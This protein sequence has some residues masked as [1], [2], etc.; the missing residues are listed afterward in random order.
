MTPRRVR[1]LVA[2]AAAAL[3][4]VALACAAPGL[5][6]GGPPDTKPPV[7]LSVTPDTNTLHAKVKNVVF[8][9]DELVSERP[10]GA[11]ALEQ[12]V[13]ISPAESPPVVDWQRNRLA[14]RPKKGWRANTAYTVTLL[15]GLADLSGNAILKPLQTEFSTG[16]SIPS[17]T[18]RGVVF[19]WVAQRTVAGARIEA[20]M[21]KDT[22]LRWITAADSLGRF[23]LAHV[24]P[25]ADLRLR[26]FHD[27]NG[28]RVLDRRE[29]WDS[30]SVPL[31]D[32]ARR[33]FY[34]FAHDSIAPRLT[35]PTLVDSTALRLKFDR[36]LNPAV[37][38]NLSNVTVR[39]ADST[40]RTLTA[41]YRAGEFDSLKVTL[42]KE[43]DDSVA[44]ADTSKAGRT[45]R[46][47]ADSL[48]AKAVND[49]ISAAQIAAAKAAKDTVKRE[50][51]PKPSRPAPPIEFVLVFDKPLQVNENV[52]L[53]IQGATS[54]DG[55]TR[56]TDIRRVRGPKP[57]PKVDSTATKPGA[58]GRAPAKPAAPDP[59]AKKPAAPDT[60]V[61]KPAPPDT[62]A[63]KPAPSDSLPAKPPAMPA[64]SPPKKP[65]RRSR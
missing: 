7:L 15:P 24:P 62:T 48:R 61:K 52:F 57:P 12:L 45:A 53:D 59:A 44:K 51:P 30:L 65:A 26:V 21:G 6:P 46:A 1:W 18:V 28:N 49:S 55:M 17:G 31:A 34:V 47:R 43:H 19:D 14:V 11:S 5:P 16:D 13:V 35:E 38:F 54:L 37:A 2:M 23:T 3:G 63:R 39:N 9:F 50:L 58:V 10:K 60:A 36:S 8:T 27:A 20:T 64:A 33:D 56:K 41:L 32:S 40:V 42:K 4:A 22:V 29:P 25:T